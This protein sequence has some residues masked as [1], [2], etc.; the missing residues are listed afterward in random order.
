MQPVTTKMSSRGQVVIPERIRQQ[1]G[2][3][4]GAEFVVVARGDVLVLQR[5]SAPSW[6]QFDDLVSEARRQARRAGLTTGDVKK[7]IT[8]VRGRR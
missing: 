6:S 8:K 5:L 3:E 2:L 1:L 4:T 7:A